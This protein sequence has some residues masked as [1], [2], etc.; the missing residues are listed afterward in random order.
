M[1]DPRVVAGRFDLA[2]ETRAWPSPWIAWFGNQR[3]P[4][5]KIFIGDQRSATQHIH[6]RRLRR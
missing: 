2:Y 3:S 5:T 4:L 6:R 1:A